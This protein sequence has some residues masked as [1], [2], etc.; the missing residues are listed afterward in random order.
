MVDGPAESAEHSRVLEADR[1]RRRLDGGAV[2]DEVLGAFEP[3]DLLVAQGRHPGGPGEQ[4]GQGPLGDAGMRGQVGEREGAR[5]LRVDPVL[6]PVD[7]VVDVRPVPNA[8]QSVPATSGRPCAEATTPAS[9]TA[10]D[11]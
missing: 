10:P 6:D 11:T 4:P 1:V 3:Q 9:D 7:R 2:A 8:G 5:E